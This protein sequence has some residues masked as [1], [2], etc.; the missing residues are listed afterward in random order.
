MKNSYFILLVFAVLFFGIDLAFAET[1]SMTVAARSYEQVAISL[2]EG[3]VFD[4][5]ITVQGGSNDD[6]NVI[7][8]VPGEDINEGYVYG[9]FSDTFTAPTSGTYMFT[10]DNTESFVSNKYVQFSYSIIKNTYYI[11]IDPLPEWAGY[12]SNVMYL[13]TTAWHDAN[14]NLNFYI[15]ENYSDADFSVKW[16]KEFGVEHVG[17]AY[18]S[19]F[20]EVGLGDSNC[21][22]KWRPYSEHHVSQ[23]MMHEIGHILGLE[24]DNNPESIM[25][26]IALNTEYG[27]IEEEYRLTQ[28]Y[29]QFVSFCTIKD[30]TSYDVS[31]TTTDETYGFDY[32]IV[33]SFKEFEKWT[34]GESFQHYSN[35]NCF[36]EGWLSVSGTCNGIS[37]GSGIMILMDSKTTSPLET[38]TL[39]QT[40]KSPISNKKSPI[41]T[42]SYTID[43]E[44][45]TD[46]EFTFQPPNNKDVTPPTLVV[47][48]DM[49][50]NT[51][52]PQGTTVDYQVIAIDDVDGEV[53]VVCSPSANSYFPIGKTIVVCNTQDS[54]GN[55]NDEMFL[56][57]VK[58]KFDSSVC[59]TG[60]VMK[61]GKCVVKP[62][63]SISQSTDVKEELVCGKGTELVNGI[64]QVIK[65]TEQSKGGGCLIATA[66]YGSELAPQVQQL[67]ELRDNQ[68]LQTESGSSFMTA[69]NDFYYSF[70]PTIADWERESP[71]FKEYVKIV[72]TPMLSTLSIMTLADSES[73]VLGLGISVIAL[74]LGMYFVAPVIVVH[75]IRKRF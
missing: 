70:S 42:K 64:C 8:G 38:I 22:G 57:T 24:H 71:I 61:D 60:T 44:P 2:R 50:I 1:E 9:S 43:Y 55:K 65:T 35:D 53:L 16:V 7:I 32:Y 69:F 4:Y 31:I 67:R 62:T 63:E 41:T 56:I 47:P 68:L 3:D 36:G 74:N 73:E 20:V 14:P 11:Y 15:V 66:T 6:I 17:Y 58:S 37:K 23:I 75:T 5:T 18:G 54:S 48:K 25:Y 34:N 30:V 13:S 49:T 19:Q 10:F 40:E 26:P 59:G 39:R 21:D 46:S 72:I 51:D 28:G 45:T 27:L 33:P 12:A 52:D 29:G